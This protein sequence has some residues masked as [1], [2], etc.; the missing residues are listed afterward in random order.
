MAKLS[1]PIEM[2]Q[3]TLEKLKTTVET[4]LGASI[5]HDL[6]IESHEDAMIQ[7][8]VVKLQTYVLA[9]QIATQRIPVRFEDSWHFPTSPWQYWKMLYA[10]AWLV[11]RFP[12]KFEE[13]KT[14]HTKYVN[15]KRYATYP[16]ANL[17]TKHGLAFDSVMG[18]PV[19][20]DIVEIKQ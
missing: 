2:N 6:R 5:A 14:E 11:H 12:V 20:K 15:L 19:I 4:A 9:E 7:S 17:I 8:L 18:E 3:W 16:N 1:D 10:P 13:T